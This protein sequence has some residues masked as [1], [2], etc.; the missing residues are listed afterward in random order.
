[1]STQIHMVMGTPHLM[2]FKLVINTE[3]N[4]RCLDTPMAV[5]TFAMS[6]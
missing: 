2:I 5:G 4:S 6:P 3:I 1:M